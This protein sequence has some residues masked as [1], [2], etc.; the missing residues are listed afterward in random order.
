MWRAAMWQ[1]V[2]CETMTMAKPLQD[3]KPAQ[4]RAAQPDGN[5]WL[6]A[7]A[8]TGKTQVLSAR[9]LRL[10]LDGVLPQAILCI[11]FTKAGAAE[12]AHRVQEKLADWV[13]LDEKTLK[14]E[15]FF[16]GADNNDPAVVARARTLF[17]SVIDAPGGGIRIQTIHSFGQMLLGSFPL[18][19][20]MMPG[21]EPLEDGKAKAL[22]SEVLG[23]LL[24]SY[25]A[26]QNRVMMDAAQML[27]L[28][29][30]ETSAQ[31]FL[32]RCAQKLDAPGA[33]PVAPRAWVR[34]ALKLPDGSPERWLETKCSD[35]SVDEADLRAVAAAGAAWGT[36]TGMGW[37]DSI[38]AWLASE[39]EARARELESM[40][41]VVAKKDGAFRKEYAD[42]GKQMGVAQ[43]A[44]LRLYD[45]IP[46]LLD[47][48]IAM[49]VA[50]DL[51]DAWMI[52]HD[53]AMAYAAAKRA[54]G[55][56]DFDDLINRT[57]ELLHEG[58]MADWIRYKLDQRID[59]ILV[60]EAQDTNS[61]QWRII[62]GL[63]QEFFAGE[64]AKGDRVRT[65][66]TV[67]D[68]KQA[69][70]GFQGT[71]PKAFEEARGHFTL[72]GQA[73]QRPFDLIDLADNFRS[74][75]AV[76]KV[77]DTWLERAGVDALGLGQTVP[78]H[79]SAVGMPGRVILWRALMPR[80]DNDA[81]D[82]DEEA[83]PE[84]EAVRKALDKPSRRFAAALAA[85][86]R[87]WIDHG[88]DGRSVAPGDIMVLVRSRRDLAAHIVRRL[89]AV[90]VDVAGVDRFQLTDPLAVQD[91]LAAAK[92]AQQP[93]D[94]LNLAALL[95]SPLVGW[96]QDQLYAHAAPRKGSLWDA[97]RE[98]TGADDALDILR[99]ILALADYTGPYRFF[100]EILSGPIQGRTK[101][102]KRLGEQAR[103]PIDE[104]LVQALAFE[105]RESP[106]MARFLD[107]MGGDDVQIKRSAEGRGDQVRVM[108]VHG[109]KGLQ[110]P[111][112][113]LA[114]ATA[115]FAERAGKFDMA[116]GDRDGLPVFAIPKEERR[117][118]VAD[119]Q[120][121]HSEREEREYWRLLYVAMTRAEHMLVIG[122]A[123]KSGKTPVPENSWHMAVDQT[124]EAMGAEW[125]DAG[126]R[127]GAR[128][129]FSN[130]AARWG[131][132]DARRKAEAPRPPPPA[133]P[134]WARRN[135]PEESRPPR[136]LAPSRL[137]PDDVGDAPPDAV[138]RAAAERGLLMHA[139]FE[140]LP[141]VEAA[142]R[143]DVAD[144]WLVRQA[145]AIDSAA[146]A[147]LIA[148][149]LRVLDHPDFA[150]VF[151]PDALAEVPLSAVVGGDV[152]TGIA[153]R[154]LV[155]DTAVTVVD[156]K[157]AR[158][159]PASAAALP[160]AYLRQMAAYVAALRVIFPGRTVK[161][162][163]LYTGGPVLFALDDA[164][165]DGHKP[166][167]GG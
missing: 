72:L 101:L 63:A 105:T 134:D 13:Q 78:P 66:F 29:L 48:A 93:L 65:L 149:V 15:L 80:E 71:D 150:D 151:G 107:W 36:K 70:F 31:E 61:R 35:G 116:L 57:A 85:E 22:Q 97:L 100:E 62:W 94:D 20:G 130:D 91:L 17:A 44:A 3:L 121:D 155:T 112:V 68:R 46:A 5:V 23:D 115:G 21:F 108:T 45:A 60:D 123:A 128:R 50:D 144:R 147:A 37:A 64:G 84:A 106:V 69:I 79:H 122:G 99:P 75:P 95:V 51:A 137:G 40:H 12:M 18:E 47:T 28:R 167:L 27:S 82:G 154:L 102:L 11:T 132:V 166:G 153:D 14:H 92:F 76:L 127:W 110:A 117:G 39:P 157:T 9:V 138:L 24:Q 33:V 133:I 56:A 139:L 81:D 38:A 8:G 59:H 118:L 52:G 83:D 113:I 111:I 34:S 55:V 145:P 74:A 160:A 10:L 161:A 30:G 49:R 7:S 19:A 119:A 32:A 158:R 1:V 124:L 125:H 129:V 156:F 159:V 136:P 53:F 2:T 86:V 73:A 120:K 77:V 142:R 162:A 16:I 43:D 152:I 88:I 165:L 148:D 98:G 146:R 141:D 109:S 131:K 140:R 96:S 104:L 67:G 135:P 143:G 103:D 4:K 42:A 54:R 126:P 6:N 163:L 90:G 87:D 89:Q 26:T 25:A 58:V 41:D 164:L 114:D